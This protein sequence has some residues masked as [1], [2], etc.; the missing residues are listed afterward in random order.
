MKLTSA[1]YRALSGIIS[2]IPGVG[3]ILSVALSFAEDMLVQAIYGLV[4]DDAAEEELKQNQEKVAAAAEAAGLSVDEYTKQYNEDGTKKNK[5]FFAKIG[6]TVKNIGS[7]IWN[8]IKG[9]GTGIANFFGSIFG[10]GN[11]E[12]SGSGVGF[13]GAGPGSVT[14]IS[15]RSNKY[16]KYDNSM[17]LAG[18]GPAAFSMVGSAYGKKLD[19]R[20]MSNAAYGM[21]MRASDGGTN[22][23]FFSKAANVFG[24]GFGMQEGPV[25]GNMIGRNVSKGQPV[26]VMGKGGP[27]GSHMHYLV[28]DGTNGRG[29]VNYVDPMTGSRKTTKMSSLT[30]NTRNAIYSYGT[31]AGRAEC[32]C[33]RPRCH[34]NYQCEWFS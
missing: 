19:P 34:W 2:V 32:S 7:G 30:K 11:D 23:A 16:N 20:A 26:V 10:G 31:G 1:I 33:I 12:E 8:G 15:Q 9:I 24:S 14:P 6:E 18:C 21:G 5:G 3:T 25:S 27:Y 29:G 13:Y 4:A 22:P 17:A 28:A